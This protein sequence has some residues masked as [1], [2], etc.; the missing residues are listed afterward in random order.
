LS[1]GTISGGFFAA[2]VDGP[3]AKSILRGQEFIS[4]A[5]EGVGDAEW[6][7]RRLQFHSVDLFIRSGRLCARRSIG[8][9]LAAS[10]AVFL[11]NLND[12]SSLQVCTSTR[13]TACSAAASRRRS[14]SSFTAW[15]PSTATVT[16]R[17]LPFI[18]CRA[19]KDTAPVDG[20]SARNYS[21]NFELNSSQK[22][23]EQVGRTQSPFWSES[24]SAG[25]IGG[26]SSFTF[27]FIS[28]SATN[29]PVTST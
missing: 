8:L 21:G 6:S 22:R 10:F 4:A 11:R 2:I 26:S 1:S 27:L 12:F 7:Q 20:R 3:A 29:Q 16:T 13:A 25:N 19:R 15:R 9:H 14:K 17:S 24:Y 18:R 23:H 5:I 28:F